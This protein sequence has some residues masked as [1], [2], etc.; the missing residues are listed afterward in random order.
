MSNTNIIPEIFKRRSFVYRKLKPLNSTW[1]QNNR[2][3]MVSSIHEP[4]S[5][6]S[7]AQQLAICDLS[8]L[9]RTGF[10]G[11]GT[12]KWFES[13]GVIIPININHALL[14]DNG[15]LIARLG[16]ND[17]LVLDNLSMETNFANKL[18]QQW[19]QYYSHQEKVCG[20]IMPRQE[21]HACFTISGNF[22]PQMFA[23]LCAIDLR[24]NKFD[25]HMI[26]QTSLARLGVIIIR[27]DL[28]ALI[29]YIMLIESASAEYTWDCLVDAMQEFNGQIIG[30]SVLMELAS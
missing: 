10:K 25:N 21:S 11:A 6:L 4:E 1:S 18:E 29:N 23:K 24:A 14:N 12:C 8:Y 13:Q 28:D 22:A 27:H 26:A 2:F 3:A 5:E 16:T 30:T 17:I 20:F 19:Q 7:Y 15:C 9:Q